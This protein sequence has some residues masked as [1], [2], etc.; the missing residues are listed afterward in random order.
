[1]NWVLCLSTILTAV[2]FDSPPAQAQFSGHGGPVRA[3]AVS[4][5]GKHLLSGSF[6]TAAIVWSLASESAEQVLRFHSD[7]VNAVVFL[8]DGRM[9]SAG[10]DARI[11]VW[12]QGRRSRIRCSRIIARRLR[13]LP[14]RPTMRRWPP[15]PGT[16]PCGFGRFVPVR[17]RVLEGHSQNVRRCAFTPDGKSVVSV[18]YDL[19]L[20]IWRL[21]DGA[22]DVIA[23]P[24]PL[25]AVVIAADGE[26]ATGGADGKVRF[27]SAGN[28]P[29]AEVQADPTP[30]VALTISPDGARIAAAGIGGAVTI[31]DRKAHSAMR[32]LAGPGPPVWSVAFLPDGATLLTGGADGVIRR[33]NAVTGAAVGSSL[34]GTP[35]DPLAAYAGDYGAEIFRACVACHTL[36]EKDG[37]VRPDTF[38]IVRP[39][40]RVTARLSVFGGADQAEHRVDAGNRRKTVRARSERLYARHQD[41]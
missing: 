34:R 13:H 18:G 22:P 5:D 25:N 10:A 11:A 26:I 30:I 3:I 38:R 24:S 15:L 41:A 29:A 32:T 14:S 33:W 37:R 27:L 31:I 19:T 17:R 6:D 36:S 9:A 1:M 8:K 21:P 28:K 35:A 12:S 7:A 23:L 20:R 16:A 2:M 40:D 4:P 39:Q